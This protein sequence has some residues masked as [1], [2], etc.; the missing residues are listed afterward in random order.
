[1][2]GELLRIARELVE[3]HGLA[4][5]EIEFTFE[6]ERASSLYILQAREIMS[7]DAVEV[8]TFIPTDELE[9]SYLASGIG[10]GGGALSGVVAH[11]E[12][13]IHV[14]RRERPDKKII[15]I[16]PNT[17]PDDMHLIFLADGLLTPRGGC[18][19]HA[20]VAAQRIGRTCVGG[21]RSP[22]V[23]EEARTTRLADHVIRSGDFIGIN[24]FDGS[25]YLHEHAIKLT[26]R[27]SGL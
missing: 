17:V 2:Y 6:N 13:D 26:R 22:Q 1:M 18:T 8:A 20:A 19:S 3:V 24:G 5:Q 27:L 25:V 10:V 9:S 16:R 12:E 4:H 7:A 21:C 15:L 14:F 11:T 23:D